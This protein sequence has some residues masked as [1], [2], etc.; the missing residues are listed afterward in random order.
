MR[1]SGQAGPRMPGVTN[2]RVQRDWP[3]TYHRLQRGE[4]DVDEA[5]RLLHVSTQS[6]RE[7]LDMERRQQ[8]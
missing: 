6:V 2:P 3:E 5:S 8:K 1:S 7:L 4:I